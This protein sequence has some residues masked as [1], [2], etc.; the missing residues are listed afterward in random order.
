MV[1]ACIWRYSSHLSMA[2]DS[3]WQPI[4]YDDC[5]SKAAA[6]LWRLSVN[7]GSL[8]IGAANLL[9]LPVHLSSLFISETIEPQLSYTCMSRLITVGLVHN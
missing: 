8:F 5:L 1:V 2:A 4:V 9:W 6:H 7:T 3:P